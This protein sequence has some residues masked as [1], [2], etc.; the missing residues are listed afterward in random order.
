MTLHGSVPMS[1]DD[2]PRTENTF[3]RDI[4]KKR[5]ANV[6]QLGVREQGESVHSPGCILDVIMGVEKARFLFCS[7]IYALILVDT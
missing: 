7:S 6:Q 3:L 4:G 1:T 2:L 5:G